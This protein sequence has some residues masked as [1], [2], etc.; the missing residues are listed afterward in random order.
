MDGDKQWTWRVRVTWEGDESALNYLREKFDLMEFIY[1]DSSRL[2]FNLSGEVTPLAY[3][4]A[5]RQAVTELKQA[6][7]LIEAIKISGRFLFAAIERNEAARAPTQ[8]LRMTGFEATA[9][10][11]PTIRTSESSTQPKSSVPVMAIIHATPR[12][13]YALRL[14]DDVRDN[15]WGPIYKVTELLYENV[16]A[17]LKDW[18]I[19]GALRDVK[20]AANNPGLTGDHCRHA[21][22]SGDQAKAQITFEEAKAAVLEGVNRWIAHLDQQGSQSKG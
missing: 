15:D 22:A 5:E 13:A 12:L 1:S 11:F 17:Q 8:V 19:K 6:N 18:G 21:V 2:Y 16:S 4:D 3:G 20:A 7:G 9:F 14:L 10:G